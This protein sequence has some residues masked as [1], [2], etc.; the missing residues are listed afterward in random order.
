[1]G[2]FLPKV[3]RKKLE[4][5]KSTEKFNLK[6]NSQNRPNTVFCYCGLKPLEGVL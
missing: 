1:M 6:L 4:H 2:L 3:Q 5:T